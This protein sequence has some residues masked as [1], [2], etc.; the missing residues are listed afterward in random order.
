MSWP[1]VE[2][3]LVRL[4]GESDAVRQCIDVLLILLLAGC[5]LYALGWVAADMRELGC[6][7]LRMCLLCMCAVLSM[8]LA[9]H[10]FHLSTIDVWRTTHRGLSASAH[11]IQTILELV[12]LHS[13]TLDTV[14]VNETA[15]PLFTLLH[16]WFT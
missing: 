8:A 13:T 15:A 5:A 2:W 7:L 14:E 12:G 4:L 9:V 10:T 11:I 3:L 1:V 6:V 16:T